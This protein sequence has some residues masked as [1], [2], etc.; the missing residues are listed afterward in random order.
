MTSVNHTKPRHPR[1]RKIILGLLLLVVL[2]I[3]LFFSLT[4][5]FLGRWIIESILSA[6]VGAQASLGGI[7]IHNTGRT[8]LFNLRFKAPGVKGPAAT[9]FQADRLEVDLDTTN[10]KK[11]EIGLQAVAAE[12]ILARISQ[13]TATSAVNIQTWRPPTGGARGT[14]PRVVVRS[15]R[16]ELCEHTGDKITVLKSIQV[17]GDVTPDGT[18]SVAINFQEFRKRPD[19]TEVLGMEVG[20]KLTPFGL[21][22][23]LTNASLNDW[24]AS[25]I[26]SSIRPFFI[27]L[28]LAGEISRARLQYSFQSAA[29]VNPEDAIQGVAATLELLNIGVS[30]PGITERSDL[31]GSI[32]VEQPGSLVNSSEG[33]LMRV[34]ADHGTLTFAGG[35]TN[36]TLS[37]NVEGIPYSV[38]ATY[39]GTNVN[40]GFESVFTFG[41][42]H[43][44]K[45]SPVLRFATPLVLERLQDFGFPEGKVKADIVLYREEGRDVKMR[46]EVRMSEGVAA[47]HR[48][49][50]EF[51][52][53]RAL[54]R[55][56]DEEIVIHR[57]EGEATSGAT[58]VAEGRIAP[59][60]ADA[61]VAVHVRAENVPIDEKVE[62]ALGPKRAKLIRRVFNKERLA[63][64]LARGDVRLPPDREGDSDDPDSPPVFALGGKANIDVKVT[65]DLGPGIDP[66]H[67]T[68]VID[69]LKAGLLPERFPFPLVAENVRAVVTD[70]IVRI[71]SVPLHGLRGGT[72]ILSVDMDARTRPDGV[73]DPDPVIRIVAEDFPIDRTLVQAL[74]SK[75]VDGRSARSV[76]SALGLMGTIDVTADVAPGS[77]GNDMSVRVEVHPRKLEAVPRLRSASTSEPGTSLAGEV[78]L[79]DLTGTIIARDDDLSIDLKGIAAP[80][81][82]HQ[83]ATFV[84]GVATGSANSPFAIRANIDLTRQKRSNVFFGAESLDLALPLEG[85]LAIF[86]Q[87]AGGTLSELRDSYQ[88]FGTVDLQADAIILK[89]RIDSMVT[90]SSLRNVRVT[91]PTIPG[92]E[93]AEIAIS[94]TSGSIVV[95]PGD[96]GLPTAIDFKDF[97]GTVHSGSVPAGRIHANGITALNL[98][99]LSH[100][101]DRPSSLSLNWE[102]AQISSPLCRWIGATVF[103]E[104]AGQLHDRHDPVGTFDLSLRVTPDGKLPGL[105]G[106]WHPH[107]LKLTMSDGVV[108]FPHITGA[109]RFDRASVVFDEVMLKAEKW[110]VGASGKWRREETG[111]SEGSILLALSSLGVPAD[112]VAAAPAGVCD[113][114]RDLKAD[115]TGKVSIPN[116]LVQAW[117]DSPNS[118]AGKGRPDRLKATGTL[119]INGG[120]ADV[121]VEVSNANGEVAFEAYREG[122]DAPIRYDLNGTFQ[123]LLLSGIQ[124]TNGRVRV[125][126]GEKPGE[127]F[128]PLIS[129][130]CHDGRIAAQASVFPTVPG[131]PDGDR[132][133]DVRVS[134]SGVTLGP[135]ID[136]LRRKMVATQ[137]GAIATVPPTDNS[138]A[139]SASRSDAKL[140]VGMTLAGTLGKPETKRGRGTASAGQGRLVS[141]PLLTRLTEAT[142]LVLPLGEPLDLLQASYFVQGKTVYFEEL[143]IFSSSVEFLGFGTLRWPEMNLDMIFTSRAT[144]RLPIVGHIVEGLRNELVTTTVGGTL[145]NPDFGVST[146]RGTRNFLERLFGGPSDDQ[147]RRMKELERRGVRGNDRIRIGP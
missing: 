10:W 121:G 17:R 47:F 6:Q 76:V 2:S 16:I 23:V 118:E 140:D 31:V 101:A 129:G 56:T 49:P 77:P 63:E 139:A 59:P 116:L 78:I 4:R 130:D 36:A 9:F 99:A 12:G 97:A 20:G 94:D 100:P 27:D 146:M 72:A 35:R 74:P 46:G 136:E 64:L 67:D 110:S 113:A 115:A 143:S 83:P 61:A 69:I 93:S 15:G 80:E 42:F 37:G 43:L 50:Y 60:I 123:Q 96:G 131:Q 70:G 26:P 41:E 112:L 88:P 68:E 109:A 11:G 54:I 87:V 21:E 62:D 40:S 53:I 28:R 55:F 90:L 124:I 32:G 5:G 108:D 135:L 92:A 105:K 7:H 29:D 84:E 89:D 52:N 38:R 14:L 106:E 65:R 48:F 126:S 71:D 145:A 111:R 114:L 122:R 22:L 137:P 102:N 85:V 95:L 142:N 128:V 91:L 107:S 79:K 119:Q 98:G 141:L 19:K 44:K 51:Q 120:M 8:D 127:T 75:E 133:F 18:D 82:G 144:H 58:I 13:D 45:D 104:L 1:A 57:V 24:P 25:T 134:L 147:E 3:G 34:N 103:G 39:K 30:L 117:W 125:V 132:D 138:T 66:W 33:R 81:Q 73:P 86:A